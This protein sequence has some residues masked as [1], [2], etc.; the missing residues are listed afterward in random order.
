MKKLFSNSRYKAELPK[1]KDLEQKGKPKKRR[2]IKNK[3]IRKMS[4]RN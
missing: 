4:L 3:K 1:D 2:K